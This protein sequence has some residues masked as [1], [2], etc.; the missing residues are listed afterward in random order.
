MALTNHGMPS[1]SF[2]MFLAFASF[3][4]YIWS[5][6]PLKTARPQSKNPPAISSTSLNSISARL[7]QDPFRVIYARS[8]DDQKVVIQRLSDS[9]LKADVSE[10]LNDES[11]AE[12]LT[13]G[14]MVSTEA[15][16]DAEERRRRNRYALVS[17]LSKAGYVPEDAG[18]IQVG[19]M[20][21]EDASHETMIIPY[22]WYQQEAG[23]SASTKKVL[24]LWLD[25]SHYSTTPYEHFMKLIDTLSDDCGARNKLRLAILG[26][27]GSGGLS[28]LI[29]NAANKVGDTYSAQVQALYDS[30]VAGIH[31]LSPSATVANDRLYADANACEQN[32]HS[33]DDSHKHNQTCLENRF[34]VSK[35]V[36]GKFCLTFNRTIHSDDKLMSELT[37]ELKFRGIDDVHSHVVLLSELDTS[38]GRALPVSFTEKFCDYEDKNDN[39]SCREHIHA[40]TYLRG[41]DGVAPGSIADIGLSSSKSSASK[42]ANAPPSTAES[43]RRPIGAGQFDYLRRIAD[44]IVQMDKD[45]IKFNGKGI[46]AIGVLGSDVYDK[47]LILHAL[48]SRLMG[49]TFFTTDLDAQFLHPSEYGWT[50]NMVIASSFGL[51]LT[52]KLQ[53]ST[54]PFRDSYQTSMYFS[55]GLA[56]KITNEYLHQKQSDHIKLSQRKS[57]HDHSHSE[58]Q[59]DEH[60]DKEKSKN[61]FFNIMVNLPIGL[62]PLLFEVGRNG[63]V[64]LTPKDAID[65][66]ALKDSHSEFSVHSHIPDE[67][68]YPLQCALHPRVNK[69]DK[70]PALALVIAVLLLALLTLGQLNAR[71]RYQLYWLAGGVMVLV[72]VSAIGVWCSSNHEEPFIMLAGIS[73][74]PTEIINSMTFIL[75]LYFVCISKRALDNNYLEIGHRYLL[76]SRIDNTRNDQGVPLSMATVSF[77]LPHKS[78]RWVYV[79]VGMLLVSAVLV[80]LLPQTIAYEYIYLMLLGWGVLFGIWFW[81]I[82]KYEPVAKINQWNSELEQQKV[83]SA[84]Q[85]TKVPIQKFWKSYGEYGLQRNRFLRACTVVL[86]FQAFISIVFTLFGLEAPP[87]R[88]TFTQVVDSVI[89]VLSLLGMLFVLFY[90]V[91]ATRLCIAWIKGLTENSYNWGDTGVEKLVKDLNIPRQYAIYWLKLHIIAERTKEVGKLIFYPFIIIILMLF[92]RINYFDDWGF[93]QSLAIIT[94]SLIAIALYTAIKLRQEAETVRAEFI[95]ILNLDKLT[96]GGNVSLDDKP[97]LTQIDELIENINDLRK[98]AFQ[99]ILEQPLVKA[100]LLLL[101][102]VGLSASQFTYLVN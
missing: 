24:L 102:G 74:W 78:N 9:K 18:H 28:A 91:D 29:N 10:Y 12:L 43:V 26:P 7:W 77:H 37:G 68:E 83:D 53:G 3:G 73:I 79:I 69:Q 97:T 93:P 90:M 98:G 50:R 39:K 11:Q 40:F 56:L 49:V 32:S 15:I 85:K 48:R 47:L 57:D 95:D 64:P 54:P 92:S 30:G 86:I 61:D 20:P 55:A 89:T 16:S 62:R 100:S 88:G 76:F 51:K 27:A 67:C 2:A 38:F 44:E 65:E 13:L 70:E 75:S 35:C 72:T 33:Q 87:L 25:A 1:Y 66:P 58:T 14:V 23:K 8:K 99:P 71:A 63:A 96:V 17:A 22:E 52:E 4:S 84:T 94:S 82:Y 46:R 21:S 45:F 5:S 81:I 42:K 60:I 6:D 59:T 36:S 101:G 80:A 31:I 34:P 41:I 19:E